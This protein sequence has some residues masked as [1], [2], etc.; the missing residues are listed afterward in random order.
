[1]ARVRMLT[2]RLEGTALCAAGTV[3]EVDDAVAEAWVVAWDAEPLDDAPSADA[4]DRAE[5]EEG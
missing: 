2:T 4:A 3:V 5:T 1:M